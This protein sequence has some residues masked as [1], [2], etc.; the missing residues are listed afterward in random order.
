MSDHNEVTIL[1]PDEPK[2]RTFGL[3]ITE[4]NGTLIQ[5]L[6]CSISPNFYDWTNSNREVVKARV[7]KDAYYIQ[8]DD[9]SVGQ[10]I[11]VHGFFGCNIFQVIEITKSTGVAMTFSGETLAFLHFCEERGFWASSGEAYLPENQELALQVSR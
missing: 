10:V 2:T 1:G 9:L 6:P 11:A 3:P 5:A 7:F 4:Y 8:K